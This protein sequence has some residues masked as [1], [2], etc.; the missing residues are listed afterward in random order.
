MEKG[1]EAYSR[2]RFFVYSRDHG[3]RTKTTEGGW[4]IGVARR[5]L[6]GSGPSVGGQWV[7]AR[8]AV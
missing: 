7:D 1:S 2:A 6:I 4:E 3:P 5:V 8:V